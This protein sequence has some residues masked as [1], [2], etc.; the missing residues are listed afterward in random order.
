MEGK[1]LPALVDGPAL[2][3]YADEERRAGGTSPPWRCWRKSPNPRPRRAFRLPIRKPMFLQR[4]ARLEPSSR[5]VGGLT[6]NRS[7]R[8]FELLAD[9]DVFLAPMAGVTDRSFRIL[10]KEMAAV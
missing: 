5:T 9:N 1:P 8:I 3:N 4:S 7:N 6:L 10:C 2:S